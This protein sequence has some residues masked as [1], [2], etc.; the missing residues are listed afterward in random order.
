MLISPDVAE[1]VSQREKGEGALKVHMDCYQASSCQQREAA[2][3]NPSA[4][5]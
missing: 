3:L 4:R 2:F 1:K 5:P